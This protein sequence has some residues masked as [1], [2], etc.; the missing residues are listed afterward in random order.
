MLTSP[1]LLSIDRQADDAGR[2]LIISLCAA[3][4]QEPIARDSRQP[5][6]LEMSLC[7]VY[8]TYCKL[9][10]CNRGSVLADL[11]A[12]AILLVF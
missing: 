3:N 7:S 4:L 10:C 11:L 9:F 1:S 12:Q 5:P 8:T 2:W 6:Q